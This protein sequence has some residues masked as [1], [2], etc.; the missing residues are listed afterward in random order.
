MRRAFWLITVFSITASAIQAHAFEIRGRVVDSVTQTGLHKVTVNF[1]SLDGKTIDQ[2]FTDGNGE[3]RKEVPQ[4]HKQFR[5]AY[6]KSDGGRDGLGYEGYGRTYPVDNNAKLKDVDTVALRPRRKEASA[7][8]LEEKDAIVKDWL[9]YYFVT[10]EQSGVERAIKFYRIDEAGF[11]R[12]VRLL[13]L[14]TGRPQP[15]VTWDKLR[16]HSG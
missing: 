2:A 4:A 10:K 3:F 14:E 13:Q 1:L 11:K 15:A 8:S 9:S 7:V 12:S 5:I 6:D 16:W